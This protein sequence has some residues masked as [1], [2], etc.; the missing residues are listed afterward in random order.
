MIAGLKSIG[1]VSFELGDAVGAK[2]VT[3]S[4]DGLVV[5]ATD[6][7]AVDGELVGVLVSQHRMAKPSIAGQ[8]I[9]YN[10]RS[11][12][13]GWFWQSAQCVGLIVGDHE[14][15]VVGAKVGACVLSQHEK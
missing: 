3:I 5:G 11:R 13:F 4:T 14:G 8:H 9:P 6:G 15:K 10:F 2:D 7:D 12:H 1:H